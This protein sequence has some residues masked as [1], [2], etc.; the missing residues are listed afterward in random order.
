MKSSKSNFKAILAKMEGL[1]ETEQGK[2]K[3]GFAVLGSN[4]SEEQSLDTN[5]FQCTCTNN[6]PCGKKDKV[7][8]P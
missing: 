2:L 7:I 5:Y 6:V 3:G 1:S 8:K 4:S